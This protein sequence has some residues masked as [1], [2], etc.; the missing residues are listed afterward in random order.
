MF[1]C[2]DSIRFDSPERKILPNIYFWDRITEFS[3][4]PEKE[5][6]PSNRHS[7]RRN[8]KA[9]ASLPPRLKKAIARQQVD[10]PMIILYISVVPLYG[11]IPK[12]IFNA[13][14]LH[15]R[16]RLYSTCRSPFS[17]LCEE[18]SD[19]IVRLVYCPY[20]RK[21]FAGWNVRLYWQL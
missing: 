11:S 3:S 7:V 17:Q 18:S 15:I 12:S 5:C 1:F 9:A 13:L 19:D 8:L 10:P 4:F 14:F 21:S 6:E 20:C 2:F 16:Y